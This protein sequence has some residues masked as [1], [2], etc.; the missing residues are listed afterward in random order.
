[1]TNP[2]RFLHSIKTAATL[3]ILVQ[4]FSSFGLGFASYFFLT[5]GLPLYKIMIIWAV[6]PLTSVP[7]VLL[8]HTWNIRRYL[9]IGLLAY[10]GMS[11]SLLFYNDYSFL[12]Y[13]VCYGVALGCFWVSF[14]YVFFHNSGSERYARDWSLYFLF[15]PL[16]GI[17]LPPIGAVI[18]TNFGF[19]ALFLL[20]AG[21]S[22]IPL[23][24]LRSDEFS[25]VMEC[26]FGE[27][28]KA[29]SGLR[30]ITFFG[31][32][33]HFF[34]G[35]FLALY[36]LLFLKTN[37]EVGGLL[38]YLAL[39]SL[40]ASFFVSY[41]S[42]RFE[43]RIEILFPLLIVMGLLIATIPAIRNLPTLL[44]VIGVYAILD[45]L[46][47]PVRFAIPTDVAATDIGFWRACELYG[48]LG[49][50]ILFGISAL[51]LYMGNQWLP[52]MIFALMT[53]SFP[54]IIHYKIARRRQSLVGT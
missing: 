19:Q 18:I 34:Q 40:L 21:L 46:S 9:R 24:Y 2:L 43:R 14:N 51:L 50:T 26:D 47:L 32:A 6:S 8:S 22:L 30:L 15:G 31:G 3:N 44:A 38:S 29:F 36:A 54:F 16:I 39:T 48:N 42:D 11:L 13:A 28:D 25:G 52:F 27:A 53:I 5:R 4:A 7:I 37:Y 41:L 23:L 1:M 20:T 45:N 49:R 10:T 35:N 17:V 12:I 33:L